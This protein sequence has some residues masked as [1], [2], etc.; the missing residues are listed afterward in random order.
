MRD[1]SSAAFLVPFGLLVFTLVAVPLHLLDDQGMPRY[2][3]LRDELA[4]VQTRN[5]RLRREIRE[6]RGDADRLRSDPRAIEHIARDELGM[7]REGEIV[8]Q[9]PN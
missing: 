1:A 4:K 6:L 3:A 5:D 8:L 7:V 2:R 9:F